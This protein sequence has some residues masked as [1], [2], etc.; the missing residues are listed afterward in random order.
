MQLVPF[1]LLSQGLSGA[2]DVE[3]PDEFL[4][5]LGPHAVGQRAGGRSRRSNLS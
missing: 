3:L 1:D 2:E 5:G 4:D